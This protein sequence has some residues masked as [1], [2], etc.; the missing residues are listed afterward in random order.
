MGEMVTVTPTPGLRIKMRS[1][2]SIVSG[3]EVI[4]PGRAIIRDTT[5]ASRFN[6]AYCVPRK[7]VSP[8]S[9]IADEAGPLAS[10][11]FAALDLP[12]FRITRGEQ[13]N[14]RRR[15][16][17]PNEA[18]RSSA[19]PRL[20]SPMLVYGN[21]IR[22]AMLWNPV[23]TA[24]PFGCF[25]AHI[26]TPPV[27]AGTAAA[28]VPE[29]SAT[30]LPVYPC[31]P[32]ATDLVLPPGFAT[33]LCKGRVPGI[34]SCAP[35]IANVVPVSGVEA[36]EY[37]GLTPDSADLSIKQFS[38]SPVATRWDVPFRSSELSKSGAMIP[39]GLLLPHSPEPARFSIQSLNVSVP[40]AIQY[41][42][43]IAS[44]VAW[45]PVLATSA[46]PAT[47]IG[48]SSWRWPA[49]RKTAA[50][51]AAAI[52]GG[53]FGETARPVAIA[54]EHPIPATSTPNAFK[55][56]ATLFAL[57]K[58]VRLEQRLAPLTGLPVRQSLPD[59]LSSQLIERLLNPTLLRFPTQMP[60]KRLEC[61]RPSPRRLQDWMPI[62][63]Q[64]RRKS[65]V[66]ER[67]RAEW[68][69]LVIAKP[70]PNTWPD[71]LAVLSNELLV[72]RNHT[73][74]KRSLPVLPSTKIAGF[75]VNQF[76]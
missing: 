61:V 27:Q 8:S 43:P 47:A 51:H 7:H 16:F 39:I 31:L 46:L 17:A 28:S 35:A 48:T 24:A 55:F 23:P 1:A 69:V 76:S 6:T 44:A 59:S 36:S 30:R 38:L 66:W 52:P 22:P 50:V 72:R 34:S 15:D 33:S 49:L 64:W 67:R 71:R 12:R 40:S 14:W 18:A 62:G 41:D 74:S 73:D 11:K 54:P 42:A 29:A 32:S 19:L 10:S 45:T 57:P 60:G 5:H 37:C 58:Q 26:A 4:A 25:P 68:K 13:A 20:Q 2:G 56:T 21:L 3:N 9:P 63:F 70:Y 53:F 65:H 75:N